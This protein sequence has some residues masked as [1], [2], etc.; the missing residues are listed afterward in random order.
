M[1]SPTG[2]LLAGALAASLA[3]NGWSALRTRDAVACPP[4]EVASSA[5]A[6]SPACAGPA[7]RT[8]GSTACGSADLE[9]LGLDATQRAA[10]ERIS[11]SACAGADRLEREADGLERELFAE[12]AA[13]AIDAG[14]VRTLV[15]DVAAL[16][17]RSL[18]SC[19]EGI[20]ELRRTL[21]RA[22]VEALLACCAPA[23][24]H[25]EAGR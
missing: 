5:C 23:G 20:V 24:E 1:R 17:R 3:W 7:A 12:L 11:S 18:E 8:G 9:R 2:S 14:R 19:V 6:A 21:S 16:R 25:D 22:Q 10:L 15:A 4:C 13:D